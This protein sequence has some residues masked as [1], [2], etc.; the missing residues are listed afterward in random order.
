MHFSRTHFCASGCSL[1]HA[2]LLALV[3]AYVG[4]GDEALG[5]RAERVPG[6]LAQPPRPL[7]RQDGLHLG[8]RRQLGNVVSVQLA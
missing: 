7:L 1:V 6:A 8:R 5:L 4:V 2:H 3:E